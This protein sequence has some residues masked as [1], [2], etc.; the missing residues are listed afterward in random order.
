MKPLRL[1]HVQ[2]CWVK[3]LTP[4]GQEELG[5]VKMAIAETGE[6]Q[7]HWIRSDRASFVDAA[8]VSSGFQNGQDVLDCTP[9]TGVRS[10]G[11]G[12]I[13]QQRVLAGSEQA[14]VD[15]PDKR[16]RH[17]LPYQYL[18]QVKGVRHR[19]L[20][21]HLGQD[22]DVE[23]LRLRLLAHAIKVWNEITG[24][25]SHLEIDPLPHQ[26]NL[27]HHILASDNLSWLI[28]DDVGLGKTIET[29]MLL[30]ALIQRNRVKRI[31]LI[32]PAGLTKQWQ[33]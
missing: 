26:I 29:G 28:A 9:G 24:S 33:D 8:T 3:R 31:L 5:V 10:L 15:F 27:V 19:F 25:L 22:T 23:R 2:G 7:V 32:T 20:R 30:H 1:A 17:W 12:V 18:R 14:L 6:V 4:S 11:L 16:E 13:M 21:A